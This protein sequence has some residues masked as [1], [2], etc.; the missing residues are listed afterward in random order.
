MSQ[1]LKQKARE[2]LDIMLSTWPDTIDFYNW[3]INTMS[4]DGDELTFMDM[5]KHQR[6]LDVYFNQNFLEYNKS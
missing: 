4:E 2:Q 5:R 3:C 6:K 1:E